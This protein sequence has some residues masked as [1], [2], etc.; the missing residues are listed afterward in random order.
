MLNAPHTM[1]DARLAI[2]AITAGVCALGLLIAG[3]GNALAQQPN[4]FT[5]FSEPEGPPSDLKPEQLKEVTFK[6]RLN[7]PLPLDET[8]K[9]EY[10]RTVRLGQYFN[11]SRPVVLAFVYYR[12]PMLC[13]QV[14]RG[15][16]SSLRALT[17]M[18][19][20]Q[21]FEVVLISFDPRDTPAA[22]L[23]KKQEHLAQWRAENTS[24]GWH[25]LTGDEAAIERVTKAAGFTYQ[26]DPVT[27]QFAHVSG[28]LVATPQGKL[29]RYF[30]GV[31]YSPK[32]LRM[33]LVDSGQ[34]KVGSLIDELLL[35]CYHYDPE[36]GRYGATV[37]NLVRLGGVLTVGAMV[38]FF[39]ISRR[40]DMRT[41]MEG[42]V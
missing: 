39:V 3:P 29:H 18:S 31:E 11:Q 15:I 12:C 16:S 32:E 34:G 10:G 24:G 13:S 21:E 5:G 28:V 6:Q 19:A 42:R 14:M 2:R 1:I 27:G 9:D 25:M 40:R 41:S 20:G 33:A 38:A 35:Y 7:E 17:T 36:T 26:F 4:F 30:Y 23:K 37:M 8:F 22:A